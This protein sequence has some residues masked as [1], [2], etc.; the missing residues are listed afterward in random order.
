MVGYSREDL[1]GGRIDWL[2]II[3]PEYRRLNEASVEELESSG[4]QQKAVRKRVYP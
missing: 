4:R 2:H 3:P 1:A